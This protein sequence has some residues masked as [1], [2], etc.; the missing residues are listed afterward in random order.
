MDFQIGGEK[1]PRGNLSRNQPYR[2]PE[3]TEGRIK[4]Y[5]LEIWV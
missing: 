1:D 5:A 4:D 2:E 3:I